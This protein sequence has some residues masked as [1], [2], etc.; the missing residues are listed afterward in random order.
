MRFETFHS[1]ENCKDLKTLHSSYPELVE[2]ITSFVQKML[3]NTL[4][5]KSLR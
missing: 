4:C 2:N 3:K 1:K 5:L